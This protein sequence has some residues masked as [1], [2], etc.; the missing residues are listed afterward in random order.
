ML[1]SSNITNRKTRYENG[2]QWIEIGIYERLYLERERERG[3]G[4]ERST[5]DD[6][7]YGFIVRKRKELWS[8]VVNG[9]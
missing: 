2:D 7:Y 8:V 3:G 5:V 4:G 1:P 6:A 9:K